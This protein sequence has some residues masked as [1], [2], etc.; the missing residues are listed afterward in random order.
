MTEEMREMF[1]Y[2]FFVCAGCLLGMAFRYLAARAMKENRSD[3]PW[4]TLT[5]ETACCFFIGVCVALFS[6]TLSMASQVLI[7]LAVGFL[8][9]FSPPYA[10]L[11]EMRPLLRDGRYM[12]AILYTV[13]SMVLVI[14]AAIA[15]F[16][17]AK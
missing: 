6:K 14:A 15:G 12:E 8:G 4:I 1:F 3:F 7:L 11:H 2:V 17:L 10:A 16:V 5:V 9:G 13:G